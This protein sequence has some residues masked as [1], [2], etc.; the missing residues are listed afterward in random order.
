MQDLEFGAA[1]TPD[2]RRAVERR[3]E[4]ARCSPRK[5]AM[6]STI[7]RGA[8]QEEYLR[9]PGPLLGFKSRIFRPVGGSQP[10]PSAHGL[11]VQFRGWEVPN[12]LM[13]R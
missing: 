9:S 7:P 11:G 2:L 6:G 13:M 3:R 4:S 8:T 5:N 10:M 12:N 1:A